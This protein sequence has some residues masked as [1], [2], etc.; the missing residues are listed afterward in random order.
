MISV[1]LRF[2]AVN[3]PWWFVGRC[4][5]FLYLWFVAFLSSQSVALTLIAKQNS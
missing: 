3:L 4:I 1:G 5:C 2:S